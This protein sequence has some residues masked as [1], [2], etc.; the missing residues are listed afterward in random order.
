SAEAAARALRDGLLEVVRS[1]TKGKTILEWVKLTPR[2][3]DF[4]H[5][6]ESPVQ[7]LRELRTILQTNRE[8]VPAWLVEMRQ[9]MQKLGAELTAKRQQYLQRLD[10]LSLRVEEA[11]RRADALGPNLP[12]GLMTTYPWAADALSF[13][14]K[15]RAGGA[16]GECALPELF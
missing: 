12:D 1:E 10:A 16:K 5:D 7:V 4:L 11:L 2:G 15:R 13:L 6:H 3:L 8:N 9:E 14:D